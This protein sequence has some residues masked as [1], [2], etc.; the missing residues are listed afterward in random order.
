MA[1]TRKGSRRITPPAG[2]IRATGSAYPP[3]RCW[4]RRRPSRSARLA[5]EAG[6]PGSPRPPACSICPRGSP[7]PTDRVPAPGR[8]ATGT[9]QGCPVSL[10]GVGGAPSHPTP[11]VDPSRSTGQPLAHR[12]RGRAAHTAPGVANSPHQRARKPADAD[13][14]H[15]LRTERRQDAAVEVTLHRC[16]ISPVRVNGAPSADGFV[17][18]FPE[19]DGQREGE[20]GHGASVAEVRAGAFQARRIRGLRGCC[21]FPVIKSDQLIDAFVWM[22]DFLINAG[23][24]GTHTHG[25]TLWHRARAEGSTFR[26]PAFAGQAKTPATGWSPHAG[27]SCHS[28]TS[29]PK[30]GKK[31]TPSCLFSDVEPSPCM[32]VCDC[33]KTES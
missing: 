18:K 19:V 32:C 31:G 14:A 26:L 3:G 4:T 5:P 1:L 22:V 24:A 27:V 28:S 29:A 13:R 12:R 30:P 21:P 9:P 11:R 16:G 17:D 25:P 10:N 23:V 33:T 6:H 2:R 15:T 20:R 8:I 7:E